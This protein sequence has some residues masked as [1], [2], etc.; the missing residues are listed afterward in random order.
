MQ[1]ALF[2]AWPLIISLLLFSLPAESRDLVCDHPVDA[3]EEGSEVRRLHA[4]FDGVSERRIFSEVHYYDPQDP[5]LTVGLGH[6][7]DGISHACWRG[8]R[9]I[10]AHGINSWTAGRP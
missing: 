4:A 8:S 2:S 7:I 6:W 3:L 10:R 9:E 5:H 1:L